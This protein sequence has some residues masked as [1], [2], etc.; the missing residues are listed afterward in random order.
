MEMPVTVAY[1]VVEQKTLPENK[2]SIDVGLLSWA[3]MTFIRNFKQTMSADYRTVKICSV[4]CGHSF[5]TKMAYI[6]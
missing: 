4:E 3:P 1:T 6:G 5:G 2:I